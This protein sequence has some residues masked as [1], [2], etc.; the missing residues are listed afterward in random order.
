MSAFDGLAIVIIGGAGS[1]GRAIVAGWLASGGKVCLVDRN[2]SA[3]TA[4]HAAIGQEGSSFFDGLI[5]LG[6]HASFITCATLAADGG[7]SA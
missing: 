6:R 3:L 1:I 2:A 7:M 5:P 4:D